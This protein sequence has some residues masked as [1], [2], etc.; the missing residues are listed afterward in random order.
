MAPEQVAGQWR[1]FG[2]W[3]D[4]YALGCL[5]WRLAVGRPVYDGMQGSAVAAA[6]LHHP[7]PPFPSSA[8]LPRGFVKWLGRLL[9]KV[10]AERY[11]TAADAAYA[12]FQVPEEA[13][14]GGTR[15]RPKRPDDPPTTGDIE[16]TVLRPTSGLAH[17]ATPGRRREAPPMPPDWRRDLPRTPFRLVGAGLGLYG[18]RPVPLVG[19]EAERD[20]LW[21]ALAEVHRTGKARA[22]LVVGPAGIGKSALV[23]WLAEHARACGSADLARAVFS[24]REPASEALRA[25]VLR[26]LRC[27]GLAPA[28]VRER[29]AG[30]LSVFPDA[31]QAEADALASWLAPEGAA[32]DLGSPVENEAVLTRLLRRAAAERPLLVWLEDLHLVEDGLPLLERLAR[33]EARCLVVASA[34]DDAFREVAL[35]RFG[36]DVLSLGP[37]SA[38]ERSALVRELLLLDA[39]LA[40]TL[41][42]RTA[43]NPGFAVQLVGEWVTRGDLRSGRTGFELAPDARISLPAGLHAVWDERLDDVLRGLPTAAAAL[44]ERAAALGADVD[45]DEWA[46]V[47]GKLDPDGTV[48]LRLLERLGAMRLAEERPGGWTFTQPLLRESLERRARDAGRWGPHNAACAAMLARRVSGGRQRLAE[49]LGRHRLE[50]GD[51]QGAFEPLLEGVEERRRRDGY[52]PALA[53]LGL[54]EQALTT[55]QAPP[56][57]PRWGRLWARRADLYRPQGLHEA[58]AAE[59]RRAAEAAA[60][61]GWTKVQREALFVLAQI[62]L[63]RNDY[64]AAS[65][66]LEQVAAF[67]GPSIPREDA[68]RYAQL[69]LARAL[70]AGVRKEFAP[71]ADALAAAA[72]VA[73]QGG[74]EEGLAHVERVRAMLAV[75]QGRVTTARAAYDIARERFERLGMRFGVAECANGQA[76]IARLQGDL[77][78]AER[79]YQRAVDMHEAIGTGSAAVYRAN[80][81]L[82]RIDRRRWEDAKRELDRALAELVDRSWWTLASVVHGLS[83]APAAGLGDWAAFDRHAAEIE[84]LDHAHGSEADVA[85]CADVAAR[86]AEDAGQL[87]RAARARRIAARQRERGEVTA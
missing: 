42:E 34:R 80:L 58:A 55:L 39:G 86:L 67:F 85:H 31:T 43:G 11:A 45:E 20:R 69:Q 54:A 13:T 52:R 9:Q 83:L 32:V 8:N 1:D 44:V 46:D 19:R 40:G 71:A 22:A 78:A 59:A 23:G 35:D 75:W 12:L 27:E 24:P 6:Q 61:H 37:L 25:M 49:R 62:E 76:E 73:T 56:S 4:L 10:P 15:L 77:D 64:A 3:T 70:A 68:P 16:P 79:G 87:V 50:A 18:L 66:L 2:P 36:G 26:H 63:D 57:D 65:A 17:M 48:R 29:V 21:S 30:W 33:V 53:L 84:M 41:E 38:T 5:A 7:P 28:E 60:E 72:A 14:S 74:Y 82:V 47:A 51:A 81:G